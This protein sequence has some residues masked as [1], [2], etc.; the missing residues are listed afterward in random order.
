MKILEVI[1]SLGSGGAE[2]FVVDLSNELSSKHEVVLLTLK[3]DSI[4]NRDFY[5]NKLNNSVKYDNLGLKDGFSLS[6]LYMVNKRIRQISPD[7]VHI[8]QAFRF[9]LLPIFFFD[10]PKY[11]LTI[12]NEI[13]GWY[14]NKINRI[15]FNLFGCLNRVSFVTISKSNHD[16]FNKEYKRCS[17]TL[18]YNGRKKEG[19]TLL[20][21]DVRGEVESFKKTFSTVVFLHVARCAPQKN[22]QLLIHAFNRL[23]LTNQDAV[24][25]ILGR[26]FDSD[27][28]ENL[29]SI[30]GEKIFFLGEKNNVQDYILNSDAL[31]LSSFY[32]GMPITVIEA[33]QNEVPVISTPV[34]GVVDVVE[35]GKTGCISADFKLDS[36]YSILEAFLKDR[37]KYS[38][39]KEYTEAKGIFDIYECA[40]KYE[41]L[42]FKESKF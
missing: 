4:E 24:L 16:G 35:Q 17:N 34:C 42:F 6:S 7:I 31:V 2:Q 28:G 41:T 38:S 30:A 5:K 20:F 21:D 3:D 25:L 29:K 33:L 15:L 1:F 8:H 36:F 37:K 40:K 11:F 39:E 18:I 27:L 12:H 9:C 32:E 10:R 13:K 23:V 26:G 14:T 19:P 22:Q